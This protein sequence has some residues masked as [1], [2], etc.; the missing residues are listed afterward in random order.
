VR[1]AFVLHTR[2]FRE[3]SL[4]VELFTE[5]AG[6]LGV[7]ARGAR[8][9]RRGGAAPQPFTR[10]R[11][12]AT[13]R[14]ELRTLG[15]CEVEQV[16]ALAGDALYAGLYLNE[17]LMRLLEREDA[18]P[19]VWADYDG[20][21]AA[22]AAGAP[23]EPVLRR[24]EFGLLGEL[25]YGLALDVD[26]R[27]RPLDPGAHYRVA[28]DAGIV[29]A[30]AAVAEGDDPLAFPGAVLLALA[31]GDLDDPAVRSAGKRI[32]RAALAPHL[33]PRPLRSRALF[34]GRRPRAASDD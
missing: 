8:R 2:P 28:V 17:L 4:I 1:S 7:V 5:D 27:G 25:G 31:A 26:T 19:D 12:E 13:G 22:L 16:H 11:F 30:D 18:H 33:G 15:A 24:F 23:L 34:A 29:P 6:R 9:S 20:A 3:T 32:A 10:L 14:G 21:L